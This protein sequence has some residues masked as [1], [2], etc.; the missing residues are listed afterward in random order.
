MRSYLQCVFL[1]LP[2]VLFLE[3]KNWST[4]KQY[5]SYVW[6]SK[7]RMSQSE[8]KYCI[9]TKFGIHMNKVNANLLKCV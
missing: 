8:E 4:M 7:K 6:T 5:I 3:K 2:T 9:L 1:L